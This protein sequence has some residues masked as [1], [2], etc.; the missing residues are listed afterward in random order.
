MIRVLASL[1]L[2]VPLFA[3]T[4][5]SPQW[6]ALSFLEGTWNAKTRQAAAGAD[7][8]GTYTFRKELGGHI[9]ARH[10]DAD[11]CKG[12]A[13]F[14]CDHGDLL[15]VYQEQ[16]GQPLRAIYFDNEGHTIHYT[17]ST[18]TPTSVLFLSDATGGPR[19]RLLYELKN[20]VME[21]KFQMNAP[22]TA[23]WTSY[24]EWSGGKK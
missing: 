5:P 24:L 23:E 10:S 14:N 6:Q 1:L 8:S 3:Q 22:G 15:Y 20:G 18:P 19:F 9:L 4:A 17:V 12:P 16:P 2:C 11:A 21:G 7:A 13:D